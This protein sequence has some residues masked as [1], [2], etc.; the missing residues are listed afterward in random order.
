MGIE[1]AATSWPE[2]REVSVW[3]DLGSPLVTSDG[4]YWIISE[5]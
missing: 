5:H 1:L 3:C 2:W 4:A